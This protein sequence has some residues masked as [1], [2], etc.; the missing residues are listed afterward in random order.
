MSGSDLGIQVAQMALLTRLL[1]PRPFPWPETGSCSPVLL[2]QLSHNP[3]T[4]LLGTVAPRPAP[5]AS[6]CTLRSSM[7]ALGL[8]VLR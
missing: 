2:P 3:R 7:A 8:P 6:A 4:W 1:L 5:Q